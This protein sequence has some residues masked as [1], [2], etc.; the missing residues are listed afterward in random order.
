MDETKVQSKF[1][2]ELIKKISISISLGNNNESEINVENKSNNVC[3]IIKCFCVIQA[4]VLKKVTSG[5][6][7]HIWILSNFYR[8]LQSH[9]KFTQNTQKNEQNIKKKPQQNTVKSYF[10]PSQ[11]QQLKI[12][13]VEN[14]SY[15]AENS[16]C[17]S[18]SLPEISNFNSNH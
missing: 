14:V 10:L 11:N 12:N 18:T 5:H 17:S 13:S 8:H 4:R 6:R 2:E 15:K 7:K 1:N 16:P 3:A 9:T